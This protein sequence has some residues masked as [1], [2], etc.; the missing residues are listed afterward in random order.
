M[1]EELRFGQITQLVSELF[2]VTELQQ[3]VPSALTHLPALML[4][5][6]NPNSDPSPNPSPNPSP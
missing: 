3:Q 6:P 4:M 2:T 1:G 5:T